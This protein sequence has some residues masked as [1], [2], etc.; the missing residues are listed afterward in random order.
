AP[1]IERLED[2][3][4]LGEMGS[5]AV[6][7]F[8]RLPVLL[9]P[10]TVPQFDIADPPA[11]TRPNRDADPLETV[12]GLDPVPVTPVVLGELHVIV[13]DELIHGGNHVEVAFPRNVV[14]LQDGDALHPPP[15]HAAGS[16]PLPRSHAERGPKSK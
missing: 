1:P 9:L 3:S 13:K 10:S 5:S 6:V 7:G 16:G 2:G 12:G 15:L 14:G 11:N 8:K 4:D